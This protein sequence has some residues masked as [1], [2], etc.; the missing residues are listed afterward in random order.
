MTTS[1]DTHARIAA[2]EMDGY[3]VTAAA[4]VALS[5]DH[6]TR[7]E[8]ARQAC[9]GIGIE[10]PGTILPEGTALWESG[11]STLKSNRARFMALPTAMNALPTADRALP[12]VEAALKAEDRRD[13]ATP[14]KSLRL[15]PDTG[16][17]VRADTMAKPGLGY[18]RHAWTQMMGQV[19]GI[20]ARNAAGVLWALRSD[21][22]S[23]IFNRRAESAPS[24]DV[25]L[26][27]KLL[28]SG[29][30]VIRAA[31]SERYA[32]DDAGTGKY[33]DLDLVRAV[34]DVLAGD[35]SARVDYK[36]GDAHSRLEVLWPSQIP[37]STFTVGD[38]HHAGIGV[39]NSE[40]GEAASDLYAFVVR[41]QCANCTLATGAGIKV[42]LRHTG[43]LAAR[44]K[45]ALQVLVGQV[46]PLI[47]S[48][49][50][51]ARIAIPDGTTPGDVFA[52]LARKLDVSAVRAEAWRGVYEAK[53]AVSPTL[54]GVTS[55]ITEAAQQGAGGWWEQQQEEVAASQ[56]LAQ[57][58]VYLAK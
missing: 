58:W 6:R 17:L 40:T 30:R 34:R 10:W 27:T 8:A 52:K 25:T 4:P 37:V 35:T 18:D 22:R 2:I 39:S 7:Q 53:Y 41:A 11:V 28:P 38:V 5:P 21:E 19:G 47:A 54:W 12:A 46:E 14:V 13:F 3:S 56:L 23:L 31:L 42:S 15:R 1:P 51:S 16:R 26:R 9:E 32:A 50:A 29:S 33:G 43:N 49:T 55:A 20:D 57:Q 48:I 45:A 44:V 36:P 24:D